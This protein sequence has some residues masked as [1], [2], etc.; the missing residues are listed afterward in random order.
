MEH[1]GVQQDMDVRPSCRENERYNAATDACEPFFPELD[2]GEEGDPDGGGDDPDGG[3]TDEDMDEGCP[4][5]MTLVYVDRDNDGV[6]VDDPET[7]LMVELCPDEVKQNYARTAEDCDDDNRARSPD[8][9]EYCDAVDND[10]N[11]M[12]NDG[13]DCT[14]WAHGPEGSGSPQGSQ[15]KLYLIDPFTKEIVEEEDIFTPSSL[16]DIDTAGDGTLYGITNDALYRYELRAG[17]WVW[18]E[19]GNGLG[20]SLSGVNGLAID[21]DGTAFATGDDILYQVNLD[22]GA[23]TNLGTLRGDVIS[24][25]DCVI[26]KR[27]TLYMTSKEDNFDSM[28]NDE[29]VQINRQD[30]TTDVIGLT[31][32]RQIFGLTAGWGKL[33]GVTNDGELIEISIMD[34]TSTTLHTFDGRSFYGSASSPGR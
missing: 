21:R 10:C 7:N 2:M 24:S 19:V 12:V 9:V 27:D 8:Q 5:T 1:N 33:F 31:N 30:L 17:Q 4:K 15:G 28:R 23:A 20:L 16:L 13:I 25:G 29:L 11:E 26:N 6:G 14:F 34:G 22:T 3:M 32:H 18:S